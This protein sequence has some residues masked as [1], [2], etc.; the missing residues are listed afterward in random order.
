M[1]DTVRAATEAGRYVSIVNAARQDAQDVRVQLDGI[2]NWEEEDAEQVLAAHWAGEAGVASD[3]EYRAIVARFLAPAS[4][5]ATAGSRA[6][7][8]NKS[9]QTPDATFV[10]EA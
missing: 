10:K 8:N 6:S 4:L 7:L 5:T 9:R 2:V 3:P 1:A